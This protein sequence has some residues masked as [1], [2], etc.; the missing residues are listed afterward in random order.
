VTDPVNNT[1]NLGI[2]CLDFD[3][4]RE[5]YRPDLERFLLVH[6]DPLQLADSPDPVAAYLQRIWPDTLPG[7]LIVANITPRGLEAHRGSLWLIRPVASGPLA[8]LYSAD[9]QVPAFKVFHRRG[10]LVVKEMVLVAAI[11]PRPSEYTVTAR[12][13]TV[14]TDEQMELEDWQQLEQL[15]PLLDRSAP[16]ID[17]FDEYLTWRE[18]IIRDRQFGLRYQGYEF[19]AGGRIRFFLTGEVDAAELDEV[20]RRLEFLVAPLTAS[21]VPDHWQPHTRRL[22][23]A[24]AVGTAVGVERTASL[25]A[26]VIATDQEDPESAQEALE[27]QIPREGFLVL[28]IAGEIGPLLNQQGAIRRLRRGFAACPYLSAFFADIRQAG[29]P[30]PNRRVHLDDDL[31]RGL[32]DEQQRAVKMALSLQDMGL[33]SGPP[34]TGKTQVIT[35]AIEQTVRYGDRVLISSQANIAVNNVL[36][37]LNE[38]P[39]VRPLRVG[40]SKNVRDEGL[41]FTSDLA[42]RRWLTTVSKE[43]ARR[44][45][46]GQIIEEQCRRAQESL[47]S[48]DKVLKNH[49]GLQDQVGENE[50]AALGE[51]VQT[52][53]T[54]R[55]DEE[56]TMQRGRA[57]LYDHQM[58]AQWLGMMDTRPASLPAAVGALIEQPLGEAMAALRQSSASLRWPLAWLSS[59][60]AASDPERDLTALHLTKRM[61]RIG[62]ALEPQLAQAETLCRQPGSAVCP[63]TADRIRAL[64]EEKRVLLNSE[65]E[66]DLQRLGPINRQLRQLQDEAWT[67][68]CRSI[69]QV[70]NAGWGGPL[71]TEVE[72][73]IAALGP[74]PAHLATIQDLR[75]HVR[76]V[77]RVFNDGFQT[78]LTKLIEAIEGYMET[79]RQRITDA[80]NRRV[81]AENALTDLR[82]QIEE[83]E[84]RL[85]SLQAELKLCRQR[86][87]ALWPQACPDQGT[88]T[89]GAFTIDHPALDA[90]KKAVENWQA[91]QKLQR[92]CHL[93]WGSIQA[94]WMARIGDLGETDLDSLKDLYVRHANVVALTCH[95]AGSSLFYRDPNFQNFDL[96][97]IDEVSK[98]TPAELLMPMLMGRRTLLAGDHRQLPPMYREQECSFT[99]AADE[100]ELMKSD[101]EKYRHIVTSSYLEKGFFW[102][103]AVLKIAMFMQYRMHSQ[104]QKIINEFYGGRLTAG[105][106]PDLDGRR[107]HHLSIPGP[108]GGRFL[109]PHHHVLWIDSSF[110]RHGWLYREKQV[111]SSKVNYLEVEVIIE[112]LLL[113]NR[114]L[115]EQ[116]YGPIQTAK[117]GSV[118]EG[119]TVRAWTERLLGTPTA[120]T[121]DDLFARRQIERGG[122]PAQPDEIVHAGDTLA[123][124]PRKKIGVI[125]F[126]GAQIQ[127]IREK[128]QHCRGGRTDPLCALDLRVSTV[129]QFQGAEAPVVLV[130][131]CR[132]K[133]SLSGGRFV[134]Q[135]QRINVAFSR[136]QELLI[137]VGA[138]E[139]FKDLSVD[140][141]DIETGQVRPVKVYRNIYNHITN[142][143]G[144]RYARELLT[145]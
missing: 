52:A 30:D 87:I 74:G 95:E 4:L 18:K 36:E 116:G 139:T 120:A 2:I 61:G 43:C 62:K 94:D 142:Y 26:L 49:R 7:S 121:L 93:R 131:L 50:A 51:L 63:E 106:G 144:R 56:Q 58:L 66:T 32:N 48:L 73:L 115:R 137:I 138:F 122:H 64:L 127:R 79:L 11:G 132:A 102:A 134:R 1:I 88:P 98:A 60:L 118:E 111:G 100:G 17:Q 124:D 38:D 107:R 37:R 128:I 143:G 27:I 33:L 133:P 68:V 110:G 75:N 46:N 65:N 92:D 130:S 42:P 103:S 91:G 44:R 13:R 126:Y 96:V 84:D 140:I 69:G 8:G 136:A 105:G 70:C 72:N 12:I 89:T 99:E 54:A 76:H 117:A 101:V 28:S 129:D 81:A 21:R 19:L 114:G 40:K 14:A 57:E 39:R 77:H 145:E 141:P 20:V 119:I 5:R 22:A 59:D 41:A 86:W 113:L 10:T 78:H 47:A 104:I 67:R 25:P 29:L 15:P 82:P 45:A 71:P 123:V 24:T 97:I 6:R 55:Q 135:Y 9:G 53:T 34:G 125:T 83:Q 3:A 35:A 80:E 23:G 16:L 85:N 109:D 90:R 31:R 112:S 108:R